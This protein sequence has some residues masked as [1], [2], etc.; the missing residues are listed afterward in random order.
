GPG[1]AFITYPEA[2]SNMPASPFFAII[3]FLML[4]ALGLGSQFALTDVP[5][6]SLVELFPR[7]KKQRPIA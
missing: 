5:I 1:L 2:I 7:L 3:F 4:L 6:T